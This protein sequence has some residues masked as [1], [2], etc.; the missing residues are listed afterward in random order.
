MKPASRAAGIVARANV[1][2]RCILTCSHL[3][4]C[5]PMHGMC[6]RGHDRQAVP[7]WDIMAGAAVWSPAMQPVWQPI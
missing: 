4:S 2:A 1:Q 3:D 6:Q 5:A 7:S